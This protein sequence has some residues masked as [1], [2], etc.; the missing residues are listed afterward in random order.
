MTPE[1]SREKMWN[2]PLKQTSLQSKNRRGKNLEYSFK[3]NFSIVKTGKNC[4]GCIF[5]FVFCGAR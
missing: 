1:A 3:A 5:G 2:V 4:P